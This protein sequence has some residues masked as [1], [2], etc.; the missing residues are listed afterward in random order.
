MSI[1]KY[2]SKPLKVYSHS[3]GN[4]N[5]L[6]F[7]LNFGLFCERVDPH[8][9]KD[10][11]FFLIYYFWDLLIVLCSLLVLALIPFFVV[12][13]LNF[14]SLTMANLVSIYSFRSSGVLVYLVFEL[15]NS[16]FDKCLLYGTFVV[17]VTSSWLAP[18]FIIYIH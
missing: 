13:A 8:W 18:S 3:L 5:L 14:Q 4:K 2:K 6:L 10:R 17:L 16:F 1:S 7:V 12:L 11:I 15:E 9:E